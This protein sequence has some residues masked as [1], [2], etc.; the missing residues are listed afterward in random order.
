MFKL[1]K[2]GAYW[3]NNCNI[4]EEH[5]NNNNIKYIDINMDNLDDSKDEFIK[6]Y[7]EIFYDILLKTDKLPTL[8][9]LDMN[10]NIIDKMV[11]F[12]NSRLEELLNLLKKYNLLIELNY[13][14]EF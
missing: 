6:T 13:D 10:N 1:L 14:E 9:I 7:D 4:L 5:L 3:C 2:I 11:G 8:Y 12:N